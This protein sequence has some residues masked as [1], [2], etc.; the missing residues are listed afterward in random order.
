MKAMLIIILF[1]TSFYAKAEF[2]NEAENTKEAIA[3]SLQEKQNF[4]AFHAGTGFREAKGFNFTD[5]S[6][7]FSLTYGIRSPIKTGYAGSLEIGTKVFLQKKKQS[8]FPVTFISRHLYSIHKTEKWEL[9]SV[10]S[11]ILGVSLKDK[12]KNQPFFLKAEL[13]TF[14]MKHITN[15]TSLLLSVGVQSDTEHLNHLLLFVDLGLRWY[16]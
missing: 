12:S 14:V 16:L 11:L 3:Q 7:E 2:K 13:G 5:F 9:G 15:K 10:Q 8:I 6:G 4:I 1:F